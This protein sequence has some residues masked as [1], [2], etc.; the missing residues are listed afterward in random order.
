MEPFSYVAYAE[1]DFSDAGPSLTV[2]DGELWIG[3]SGGG[4]GHPNAMPAVVRP[5]GSMYFATDRKLTLWDERAAGGVP[6]S[7]AAAPGEAAM[8]WTID[9]RAGELNTIIG[10]TFTAQPSEARELV[11]FEWSDHTPAL[12]QF[13]REVYVAWTGSNNLQINCAPLVYDE[14]GGGWVFS[15]GRKSVSAETSDYEP[16]LAWRPGPSRLYVA[17]TGEGD[18]ELNVMYAPGPGLLDPPPERADFDR[19]TK[20]TFSS[21]TSDGGPA[22]LVRGGQLVLAYRGSGNRNLN[23]LWTDMDDNYSYISKATSGRT[24]PYQPAI[25]SYQDWL[26]VAWTGEDH[27][28]NVGRL[29]RP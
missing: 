26:Y 6:M 23:V 18:H 12:C 1:N 9:N 25:A 20:H 2:L 13:S 19:S 7:S 8:A 15:S 14:E 11:S 3:W 10:A 27:N 21:E 5:D 28:L 22:L 16:S 17:W 24:T 4:N 29:I